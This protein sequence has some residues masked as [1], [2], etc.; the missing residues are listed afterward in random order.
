MIKKQLLLVCPLLLLASAAWGLPLCMT[1]SLNVYTANDANT[2]ACTLDGFTFSNF[3]YSSP[4]GLPTEA[5]VDVTPT[6]DSA[7]DVG[8]FFQG[9][10]TAGAGTSSDAILSYQILAATP[11]ITGSSVALNSFGATGSGASASIVEGICTTAPS[12]SG[13]CLPAS[14]AYSLDVYDNADHPPAVQ[15]ASVVFGTAASTVY[16]TK[17]IVEVGGSGSATISEF[18]N[19]IQT[20]GGGGTTGGGTPEPASLLTMGSGMIAFSMLLR[21]KLRKN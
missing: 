16:V 5:L 17:N 1:N 15:N 19:T 21:K 12:G 8:F 4:S 18:E 6:T 9:A 2:Y 3:H 10:F 13:A 20:S 11:V 7:G 14:N